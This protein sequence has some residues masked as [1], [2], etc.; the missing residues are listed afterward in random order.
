MTTALLSFGDFENAFLC[1]TITNTLMYGNQGF[2]ISATPS[3][4]VFTQIDM[5]NAHQRKVP[6]PHL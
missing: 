1:M 5:R 6:R 4:R 2:M 3:C